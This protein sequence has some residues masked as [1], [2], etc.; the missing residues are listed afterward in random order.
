MPKEKTIFACQQCGYQSRKW[1]GR[2]PDCGAWN[3]FVEEREEKGVSAA[4]LARGL[5]G[6]KSSARSAGKIA[7]TPY[8]QVPSQDDARLSSGMAE[9]DRVLGGGIVPGS[10]LLIGGDPGVGKSTLLL[11]MAAGLSRRGERVLYV[12]GEESERQIKLRGD[13]LGLH[14]GDLHLLPETCL[15]RVLEVVADLKPTLIV[16]DSV[17]TAYSERLDSAPGSVSQVRETAGQCL[18]LAKHQGIPIFL[19]GHVT[20]DGALAGPKTL[21]HIVDTVIY[22]EGE[23]H[24]N[25]RVIRAV[26][27]R[28]GATNELG[29]FEMTGAGLTPVANPSALFLQ[30]RPV[31]V[32]GSVVVACMEGTRPMLVELQALVSSGKYGTGRR[33]VEG[34][35]PNRVALLIA[36]LEKRAGLQMPGDDVFVNVAGGL[37]L[38]EPAVDLGIVAALASS[39][40]NAA[41][42]PATVVFGEVGLAGEVRAVNQPA[43]RLREVAAMGFER[44][45]MPA[46]NVSGLDVP[47]GVGVVGVR[48]V[49]D[50]LDALF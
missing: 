32:A 25:H 43:A 1:L 26:K 12:S 50:A 6:A 33:T 39:F 20:K 45:I 29:M 38:A 3:S 23:R 40:R 44:V 46:G 13:R 34:V 28:F 18:L 27:N 7:P 15:E 42:D 48:S 5:G 31:G 41:I 11:Q 4:A 22:F 30:Q 17:Q 14:P 36:M 37:T 2:C 21:E 8:A 49:L 19:I 10:L 47:E 16:V 35:E 24:H 9:L